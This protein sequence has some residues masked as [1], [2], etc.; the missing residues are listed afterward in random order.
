MSREFRIKPL[1]EGLGLGALR[2]P[3]STSRPR[4]NEMPSIEIQSNER[5]YELYRQQSV[6]VA[7]KKTLNAR[8][9]VWFAAALVGWGL[10]AFMVIMTLFMCSVLG[11]MAWQMGAG[12]T[13]GLDPIAALRTIS[14]YTVKR[15]PVFIG[16]GVVLA[17]MLYWAIM[18]AFLGTTMGGSLFRSDTGLSSKSR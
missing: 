11:V 1:S 13:P 8:S 15:G 16:G 12:I 17:W 3:K 2:A 4:H 6:G 9:K 14:Q 7:K 18:K 10:D 5:A